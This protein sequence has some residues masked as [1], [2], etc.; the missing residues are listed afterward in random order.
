[1]QEPGLDQ[2][3]V[4]IDLDQRVVARVG[5]VERCVQPRMRL[6][7]RQVRDLEQLDVDVLLG[8][9][10]VAHAWDRRLTD[11]EHADEDRGSDRLPSHD[12]P[13]PSDRRRPAAAPAS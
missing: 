13:R 4:G 2:L 7:L 11:V 12:P 10:Q 9:D 5:G 6:T 1:M 3:H 8:A